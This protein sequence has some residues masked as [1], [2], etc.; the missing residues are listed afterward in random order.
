MGACVTTHHPTFRVKGLASDRCGG[1][2]LSPTGKWLLGV[3]ETFQETQG[4]GGAKEGRQGWTFFG[5]SSTIAWRVGP[6]PL[7][8]LR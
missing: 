7:C 2:D 3:V 4:T 5:S 1:H 6:S 8:P